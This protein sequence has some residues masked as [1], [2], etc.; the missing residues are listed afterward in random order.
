MRPRPILRHSDH[1]RSCQA[2]CREFV[3]APMPRPRPLRRA[4]RDR[5]RWLLGRLHWQCQLGLLADRAAAEITPLRAGR[6]RLRRR[7]FPP[8]PLLPPPPDTADN[9]QPLVTVRAAL[10]VL[11]AAADPADPGPADTADYDLH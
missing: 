10:T 1:G 2:G 7:L 3:A 5:R 9:R 4:E 6:P 11:L 8:A